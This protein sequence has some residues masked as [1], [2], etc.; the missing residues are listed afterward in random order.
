MPPAI[1]TARARA[2]LWLA[3][4]SGPLGRAGRDASGATA[5]EFALVSPIVIALIL[6]AIQVGVIF[7][8]QAELE[9]A[10]EQAARIVYTNQA[11]T[12]S[13]DFK[14][15][16]CGYLQALFSC[17]SVMVDLQT[18]SISAASSDALILTPPTLTYNGSGQ[19][20]NSWNYSP[21]TPGKL[22][23]LRVLY[24]WPVYAGPLGVF[25]ANLSN[26]NLYMS[27]TQVFQ[28]EQ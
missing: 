25:F 23:I 15:D 5:I 7:F 13:S 8:A 20:T 6:G 22:E 2:E 27:S 9:N 4:L 28:N 17:S 24:Q 14:T 1:A 18:Q 11:P 19:V 26:G 3:S 21:G 12:A 10:A 16:V